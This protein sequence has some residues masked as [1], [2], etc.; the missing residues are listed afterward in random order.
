[1]PER[2]RVIRL[3]EAELERQGLR[4]DEWI[5]HGEM[6]ESGSQAVFRSHISMGG[7]CSRVMV[8]PDEHGARAMIRRHA[9]ML[10]RLELRDADVRAAGCD[11]TKPPPWAHLASGPGLRILRNIGMD[12]LVLGAYARSPDASLPSGHE[13]ALAGLSTDEYDLRGIIRGT[14][15]R[16]ARIEGRGLK[17]TENAVTM[18]ISLD[19]EM[20]ETI[21]VEA[22]GRALCD[23]IEHP[24]LHGVSDTICSAESVDGRTTLSVGVGHVA[25]DVPP[26]HCSREWQRVDLHRSEPE[27]RP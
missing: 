11:A 7:K 27:S 12:A 13:S 1:M 23:V 8:P 20:P 3:M 14:H 10:R 19:V 5:M 6:T 15:A 25:V 16:I 9:T 21:L 26:D 17:I 4:I 22:E 24:A 2:R 18:R